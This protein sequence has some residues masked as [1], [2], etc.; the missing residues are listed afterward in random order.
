VLF[1]GVGSVALNCCCISLQRAIAERAE[2]R[3]AVEE[4]AKAGGEVMLLSY[5][6]LDWLWMALLGD[7]PY[8]RVGWVGFVEGR[9]TDDLLKRLAERH[10]KVCQ[11]L[12]SVSIQGAS[13]LTGQGLKHLSRVPQIEEVC[14]CDV[15]LG[16]ADL[17][18]LQSLTQVRML[19][20]KKTKVTRAGARQ[21]QTS[22]PGCVLT[23]E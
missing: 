16:D 7:D 2:E 3:R 22:L 23:V 14:V 11:Q 15:P 9:L 13:R 4:I 18:E 17:R 6:P 1:I 20:L 10:L 5:S 12:R 8:M 19:T 21:L